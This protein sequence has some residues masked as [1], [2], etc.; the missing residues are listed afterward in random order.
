M[1]K[2]KRGAVPN[3]VNRP[4]SFIPLFYYSPVILQMNRPLVI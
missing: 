4:L 1:R 3:K 2:V